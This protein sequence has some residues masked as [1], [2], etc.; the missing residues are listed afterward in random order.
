MSFVKTIGEYVEAVRLGIKNSDKIIESLAVAAQVKNKEI[1]EEALAEI[2]R[3]KD[4]C[5]A[6]SHNSINAKAKGTYNS[7]LP[8]E[9]CILCKCRLGTEDSKEYCLSCTCGIQVWNEAHPDPK[10]QMEVKWQ[11]FV[12]NKEQN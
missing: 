12:I 2:L 7:S 9:H 8:Y 1:N 6:C 10:Q 11:A 4:I 3:R 5:A